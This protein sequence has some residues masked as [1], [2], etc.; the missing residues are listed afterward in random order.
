M[1]SSPSGGPLYMIGRGYGGNGGIASYGSTN[2]DGGIGGN[3]EYNPYPSGNNLTLAGGAG[4]TGVIAGGA[5][6]N[7]N[8]TYPSNGSAGAKGKVI[9]SYE[10]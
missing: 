1:V 7:V 9:V 3:G 2:T 6:G 8:N 4:G 5:G 10:I